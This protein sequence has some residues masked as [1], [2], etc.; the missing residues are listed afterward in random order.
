MNNT[1]ISRDIQL[2]QIEIE[3]LSE[4][5]KKL[6]N[7]ALRTYKWRNRLLILGFVLKTRHPVNAC[8]LQGLSRRETFQLLM[9]APKPYAKPI[10][11]PIGEAWA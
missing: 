10:G 5:E 1:R 9:N 7:S 6:V 3:A 8:A 4:S 11:V 2:M